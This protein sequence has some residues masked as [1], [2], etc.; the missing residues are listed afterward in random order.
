MNTLSSLV[1]SVFAYLGPSGRLQWKS[2][3]C[4]K[5]SWKWVKFIEKTGF[6]LTCALIVVAQSLFPHENN[7][8]LRC[9]TTYSLKRFIS[10]NSDNS[11]QIVIIMGNTCIPLQ[12]NC[13]NVLLRW[14]SQYNHCFAMKTMSSFDFSVLAYLGPVTRL[15]WTHHCCRKFLWK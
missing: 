5:I 3:C 9:F 1:L 13:L 6:I 2:P 14:L 8:T 15:Q 10:Y 7:V 12:N 11:V 4:R